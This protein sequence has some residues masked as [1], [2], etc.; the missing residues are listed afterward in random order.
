MSPAP[1]P[2][3]AD[4]TKAVVAIWVV[5]VPDVGV[6][7]VGAPLSAGDARGA[8]SLSAVCNPVTSAITWPCASS[9]LPSS[10]VCNPLTSPIACPWL[11]DAFPPSPASNCDLRTR[12]VAADASCADLGTREKVLAPA[13]VWEFPRSMNA[14]RPPRGRIVVALPDPSSP[15]PT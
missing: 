12:S 6:G 14:P 2:A 15:L 13:M 9:D 5:F 11:A 10:A 3:S 4:C 1:K 8:F 7:A